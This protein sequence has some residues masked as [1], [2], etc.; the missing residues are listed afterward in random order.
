MF[1]FTGVM[2]VEV[3]VLDGLNTGP[4]ARADA[5]TRAAAAAKELQPA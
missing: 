1:G 2:K 5:I 4:D 3:V